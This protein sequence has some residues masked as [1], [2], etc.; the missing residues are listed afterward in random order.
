METR[1]EWAAGNV[2]LLREKRRRYYLN[3]RVAEA[4]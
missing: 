2:D 4:K 1:A 3:R